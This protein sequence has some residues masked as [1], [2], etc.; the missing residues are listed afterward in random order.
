MY[1]KIYQLNC[2]SFLHKNIPLDEALE[3][4]EL[5][6]LTEAVD[7]ALS[8]ARSHGRTAELWVQKVEHTFTLLCVI[9]AERTGN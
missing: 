9:R 6:K 4:S 2:Q 3:S 5:S 8:K 7:A 1:N